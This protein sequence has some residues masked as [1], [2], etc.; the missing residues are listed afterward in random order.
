[1]FDMNEVAEI[2]SGSSSS[3]LSSS[4]SSFPFD[5]TNTFELLWAY[6]QKLAK[7]R[8]QKNY[9]VI[10]EAMIMKVTIH[11]KMFK[12]P[13]IEYELSLDL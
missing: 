12:K 8:V 6:L 7:K 5:P 11:N 4:M 9:L 3:P 1:M 13:N 10:S 2:Y